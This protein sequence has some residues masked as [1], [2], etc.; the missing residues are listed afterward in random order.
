MW[1][2]AMPIYLFYFNHVYC[3]FMSVGDLK[4]SKSWFEKFDNCCGTVHKN[5]ELLDY[6]RKTVGKR[7]CTKSRNNDWTKERINDCCSNGN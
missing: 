1:D 4:Y 5:V 7:L 3:T 6:P 2:E